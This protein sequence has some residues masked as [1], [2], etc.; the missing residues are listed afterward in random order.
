MCASN[1]GA[2][3]SAEA[4]FAVLAASSLLFA[5]SLHSQSKP[6]SLTSIY[7][8][9]ILNDFLEI[10]EKA[11]LTGSYVAQSGFCLRL[12]EGTMAEFLPETCSSST[13]ASA[14]STTRITYSESGNLSVLT[15]SL[16]K[17]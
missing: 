6:A 8:Y 15:A 16:W 3:F 7:E 11:G 12:N 14:V 5:A 4:L 13:P 10:R 2:F 1:K 17:P 9:Q